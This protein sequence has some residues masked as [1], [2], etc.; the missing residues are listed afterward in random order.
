MMELLSTPP[1]PLAGNFV[2]GD[3]RPLGFLQQN[4][5]PPDIRMAVK[6]PRLLCQDDFDDIEELLETKKEADFWRPAYRNA[7]NIQKEQRVHW[8]KLAK[9]FGPNEGEDIYSNVELAVFRKIFDS[10]KEVGYNKLTDLNV[11]IGKQ[12]PRTR[13][14]GQVRVWPPCRP[15]LHNQN[16]WET[17][18]VNRK[19]LQDFSEY[20]TWGFALQCFRKFWMSDP[21]RYDETVDRKVFISEF[22][23][24]NKQIES[25]L[26]ETKSKFVEDSF[27]HLYVPRAGAEQELPEQPDNGPIG[28]EDD[29]E[30]ESDEEL[31]VEVENLMDEDEEFETEPPLPPKAEK[32]REEIGGHGGPLQLWLQAT[33]DQAKKEE[34]QDTPEGVAAAK[35]AKVNTS[36]H[37]QF[38]DSALLR[39]LEEVKKDKNFKGSLD[40]DNL[41][42]IDHLKSFAESVDY[43]NKLFQDMQN[44][45]HE[46][47]LSYDNCWSAVQNYTKSHSL[48]AN[49]ANSLL[50]NEDME[51]ASK[52]AES[53]PSLE[54]VR[55]KEG[56]LEMT[57]GGSHG[58][59]NRYLTSREAGNLDQNACTDISMVRQEAISL[60]NKEY[61][62]L[63]QKTLEDAYNAY[64]N[65]EVLYGSLQM[66]PSNKSLESQVSEVEKSLQ[67]TW[68]DKPGFALAIIGDKSKFEEQKLQ[69]PETK[70]KNGRFPVNPQPPGPSDETLA[71]LKRIYHTMLGDGGPLNRY[72]HS[73]AIG[74]PDDQATEEIYEIYQK[75]EEAGKPFGVPQNCWIKDMEVLELVEEVK[76]LKQKEKACINNPGPNSDLDLFI[77][78]VRQMEV[79]HPEKLLFEAMIGDISS[80][81]RY[82]G[83][84]KEKPVGLQ[85]K[86]PRHLKVVAAPAKEQGDSQ[87]LPTGTRVGIV[88]ETTRGLRT[89]KIVEGSRKIGVYG[90]QLLLRFCI[91]GYKVDAWEVV[92]A[93]MF[94]SA[95]EDYEKKG[96]NKIWKPKGLADLKGTGWSEVFYS[97]VAFQRRAH[98]KGYAVSANT[99]IQVAK[100]VDG[101]RQWME[102][103]PL[104]ALVEAYGDEAVEHMKEYL[105]STGQERPREPMDPEFLYK[106]DKIER[107]R[108]FVNGLDP[109]PAMSRPMKKELKRDRERQRAFA[110]EAQLAKGEDWKAE[111]LH[112]RN[113]EDGVDDDSDD[114]S[115]SSD[116]DG[117]EEENDERKRSK[118][119][120]ARKWEEKRP[121]KRY[122]GKRYEDDEDNEP[123][124]FVRGKRPKKK[125]AGKRYE[126]DEPE[127][128]VRGKRPKKKSA[129]KRHVDEREV[130]SEDETEDE[131][132]VRG[133]RSKKPAEQNYVYDDEDETD[134]NDVQT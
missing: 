67:L 56:K 2:G 27:G 112:R 98:T 31:E 115:D 108:R 14:R 66:S 59:L 25:M 55:Y 70:G 22:K 60:G 123:E 20:H 23:E 84:P 77:A 119:K 10:F 11:S 69:E 39:V 29:I 120:Y 78:A 109:L 57:L 61:N 75:L 81:K 40:L 86:G 76:A 127:E 132:F 51:I 68:R 37:R 114:S 97:G 53:Q 28:G 90:H 3:V 13:L 12:R 111:Y 9:S 105:V 17:I 79:A 101:V 48:P 35:L 65:W 15:Q 126:D 113:V 87:F 45:D 122:A 30:P 38:I 128:F 134:E 117:E 110:R 80:S 116:S 102:W 54:M 91:Q 99:W 44:G 85:L 92:A 100:N 88:I 83:K 121:K 18:S 106:L 72:L 133:G 50:R 49:Y 19:L 64:K 16:D 124:E 41:L 131:I 103:F 125:S 24:I 7:V 129:G 93:S 71:T 32:I 107:K 4:N 94:K 104:G 52:R 33:V 34:N 1:T 58:A 118:K 26:T 89:E 82:M 74:S 62:N 73:A 6:P 8:G 130:S 95:R 36:W 63:D 5:P 47:K 21:S 42:D 46:A 43:G 96:E